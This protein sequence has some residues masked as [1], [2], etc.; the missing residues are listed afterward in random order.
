MNWCL[1]GILG[2]GV[3]HGVSQYPKRPPGNILEVKP[4]PGGIWG[5]H[6]V[7][8]VHPRMKRMECSQEHVW[9]RLGRPGWDVSRRV[10]AK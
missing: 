2:Y 10:G 5:G 6:S 7:D 1:F 4:E 3:G 8:L 9:Q